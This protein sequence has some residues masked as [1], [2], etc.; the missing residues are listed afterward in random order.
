[1]AKKSGPQTKGKNVGD[2]AR[3]FWKRT[4]K[5]G[6]KTDAKRGQG[7]RRIKSKNTPS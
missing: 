3:G 1:L 2:D 5:D 6:K 4:G 7:N